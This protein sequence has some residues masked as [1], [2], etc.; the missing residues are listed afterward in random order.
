M[1]TRRTKPLIPLFSGRWARV[2]LSVLLTTLAFV[3]A[4]AQTA[5]EG[6]ANP[7]R[8]TNKE[9]RTNKW[10]IYAQG[11]LSWA[12]GVWYQNF[13]AKSSYKQSPAVGG[14]ID[15]TIRPWIRVG[16][17]YLWSR[18]RREQRFSVIDN[19]VMPI[20]TYGN[21]MM[22]THN[23]KL[24]VQF[25]FMEFWPARK[26]QWFNIW[27]GTGLG[28]TLARGNEYG[29][30]INNTKTENGTSSSIG[31][32]ANISND[33]TVT[34]TGNVSTRNRH[35]NFDKLYIPATLHIEADVSRRFTVG[36]KGEMDW[37]LNRKEVAPKHLIYALAT[38][39]YNF[40]PSRAR[41]QRDYYDGEIAALN[42]RAN[43]LRQ[44]ADSE[45]ARADQE[46]QLRRNAQQQ[47][48][49]LQ[50]QLDDCQN[51]KKAVVA[52]PEHYVQF[53][54]NSSYM[55]REEKDRLRSFARSV[56]GEKLAIIAEAS[57]PGTS[58]YNQLLSERRMKR[59]VDML[60]K[61]GFA[62]QDIQPQT[63]IGSKEGKK[64]AEGRRVTIKVKK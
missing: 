40:V 26:A 30:W 49:D 27:L 54:H 58:D 9:L 25:N 23:I 44:E 11:G 14:G 36:V 12:N 22:N 46:A 3:G 18:Y 16:A 28:G 64:A 21:Y 29:M 7:P 38:V 55:S 59:V 57:T 13:D 56:K 60:V 20:K 61:E 63:A 33:G 43:S 47:N 6:I 48:A 24:G 10:S 8:D 50:R 53:A 31:S 62:P 41:K 4:Q 45:K 2:G 52:T 42:D 35:E 1:N 15:F 17:D 19:K 51:S 34:I 5:G 39:R 32:D 37:L